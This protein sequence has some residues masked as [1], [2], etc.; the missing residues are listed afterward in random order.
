MAT[1]DVELD[2][3][4]G[5]PNPGWTLTDAQTAHLLAMVAALSSTE[6]APR[7]GNQLGYRGMVVRAAAT[8]LRLHDG[9]VDVGG[10][11]YSDPERRVARWLLETGRASVG[12]HVYAIAEA[13][14]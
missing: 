12:D 13:E 1:A 11:L 5:V 8:E 4:S 6:T 3:F 14:L 9:I 2:V 7:S 10:T